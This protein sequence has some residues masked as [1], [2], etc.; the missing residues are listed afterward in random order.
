MELNIGELDNNLN[1]EFLKENSNMYDEIP[2]NIP[3]KVIKKSEKG[4]KSEK[5]QKVNKVRFNSN[6]DNVIIKQTNPQTNQLTNSQTNQRI[7][8]TIP[9]PY[10]KMVRPHVP[11]PKPKITYDDILS[12]MGMT[13]IDGKLHLIKIPDQ[14]DEPVKQVKPVKPVKPI[15]QDKP[16]Q[17]IQPIQPIQPVNP[18]I[19][20]SYIY[21]KYFSNEKKETPN[22][23]VPRNL[24]EYKIMLL[25]DIIQRRKIK[26]IKSTKLIMPTSNINYASYSSPNLNKLFNFSNK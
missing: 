14:Q 6:I 12:N 5:G 1:N 25:Q 8:Q 16:Y 11:E 18:N 22:V 9:K 10:A 26:Q 15:Q 21:N 24:Q 17:K 19:T 2:E 4:E 23:R 3:V 13:M 20:N 7:N